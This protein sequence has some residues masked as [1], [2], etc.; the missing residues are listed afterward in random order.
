V[1]K[2]SGPSSTIFGDEHN[3]QTLLKDDKPST[4][5]RR[6]Q[7]E[8]PIDLYCC[9]PQIYRKNWF[10][11]VNEYDFLANSLV[12]SNIIHWHPVIFLIDYFRWLSITDLV[13][14]YWNF[15]YGMGAPQAGPAQS[16]LY[17]DVHK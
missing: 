17:S 12:S 14:I 8:L 15:L 1:S 13:K 2:L 5:N 4:S 10:S 11:K 9:Y 16:M 3:I 6:A 7:R